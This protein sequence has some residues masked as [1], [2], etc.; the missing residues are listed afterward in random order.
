MT[1]STPDVYGG[2]AVTSK[3]L[4]REQGTATFS[5][6]AGAA[7]FSADPGDV[8]E[9]VAGIG[10]SDDE[11]EPFGPKVAYTVPCKSNPTVSI[12]VVDDGVEG[13]VTVRFWDPEDGT[14]ISASAPV[15]IDN[16]DLFNIKTEMQGTFE[17]DY[18]NRYCDKGN[19]LVIKYN[20]TEFASWSATDLSGAKFPTA[21]VPGLDTNAASGYTEKAF[22]LPVLK[23]NELFTFYL[24]ADATGSGQ[25]PDG[26]NGNTTISLYDVNWF[27]NNDLGTPTVMCG[28]EDE[29][30]GDVGSTGAVTGTVSI[31][32]AS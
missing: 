20:N 18:G 15:D 30:D 9:I 6:V 28:V 22:Q 19:V 10:A 5:E 17:T 31:T 25:E 23:S 26:V 3:N 4:V 16:G 21:D 24:V 1:I 8:Y 11:D 2:A 27:E 29:D 32:T 7:T 12:P 13:G 14:T